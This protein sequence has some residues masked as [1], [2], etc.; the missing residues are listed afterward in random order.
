MVKR[1]T[2]RQREDREDELVPSDYPEGSKPSETTA[3]G[4]FTFSGPGDTLIGTLIGSE[5]IKR[6]NPKPKPGEAEF[7]DRWV[8]LPDGSSETVYLPN[9]FDLDARLKKLLTDGFHLPIRHVWI[10][11]RGTRKAPTVKSGYVVVYAV[12]VLRGEQQAVFSP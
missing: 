7:E 1:A 3:G 10:R 6:S 2:R 4:F 12:A 5:K 9:H 8:M 11:L